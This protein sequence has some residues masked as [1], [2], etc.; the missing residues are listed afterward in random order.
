MTP[1]TLRY[2]KTHEWAHLDGDVC[3]VGIT[4]FATDQ[5]TD[6]T[7]IDL[8]HVG[9]HVFKGQEC[10]T[11]ETVKAV[12]SLYSPIDGEVIAVNEKVVDDPNVLTR[13]PFGEGWTIKVRIEK[14]T[15]LDH[16]LTSEQ[17]NKQ[18]ESEA[19]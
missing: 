9:D 19:Q 5:L 1:S 3:T 11:I 15:A 13:D 6:V 14:P 17:Y 7:Y 10:G 4:K 8:P 2:T 16:L 18:V 12:N